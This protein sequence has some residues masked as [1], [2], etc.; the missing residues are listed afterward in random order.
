MEH[1]LED[2]GLYKVASARNIE[3]KLKEVFD[4]F[5]NPS[6]ASDQSPS[7]ISK[8]SGPTKGLNSM[9]IKGLN[10]SFDLQDSLIEKGSTYKSRAHSTI[11][12][13]RFIVISIAVPDS[14]MDKSDASAIIKL[15]DG[16]LSSLAK[17]H[18]D[19]FVC[20]N[21]GNSY[22]KMFNDYQRNL[23]EW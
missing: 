17:L 11:G 2:R 8:I 22:F 3:R 21:L 12:S 14:L 4:W 18:S 19:D 1:D 6:V 16:L 13:S 9:D 23:Q 5:V 7:D 20:F 15:K 10:E